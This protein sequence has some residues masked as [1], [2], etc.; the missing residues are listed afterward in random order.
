MKHQGTDCYITTIGVTP[1]S[2][3]TFKDKINR[4]GCATVRDGS[5]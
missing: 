2:L 4:M 1:C 5:G 3:F